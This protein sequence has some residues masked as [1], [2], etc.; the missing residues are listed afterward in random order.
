MSGLEPAGDGYMIVEGSGLPHLQVIGHQ[1]QVD[2]ST[3]VR[4]LREAVNGAGP[5][6]H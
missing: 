6:I 4:R 3:L 2:W 5:Q 1:T